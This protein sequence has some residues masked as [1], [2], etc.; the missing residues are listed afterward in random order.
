MVVV[1]VVVEEAVVVVVVEVVE[2]AQSFLL[3]YPASQVHVYVLTPSA[4]A[5]RLEQVTPRQSS[6]LISQVLPVHPGLQLHW[7]SASFVYVALF[8]HVSVMIASSFA[9]PLS[10]SSCVLYF[11]NCAGSKFP[12]AGAWFRVT[13]RVYQYG[14]RYTEEKRRKR[15]GKR[16]RKGPGGA[17]RRAKSKPHLHCP[18]SGFPIPAHG[19]QHG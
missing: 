7:T 16:N 8:W 2:V 4:Q 1:V 18:G 5:P 15:R 11:N 10:H 17:R 6:T 3:E 14:W 19:A 13:E 12:S 9:V